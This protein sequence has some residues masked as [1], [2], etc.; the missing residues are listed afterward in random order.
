MKQLAFFATA[1][2]AQTDSTTHPAA[3]ARRLQQLA[4][5]RQA[6]VPPAPYFAILRNRFNHRRVGGGAWRLDQF[7]LAAGDPPN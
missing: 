4:G 7:D 3:P 1:A 5:G 2:P 6:A